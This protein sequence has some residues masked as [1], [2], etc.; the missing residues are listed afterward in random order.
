MKGKIYIVLFLLPFLLHCT[1]KEEVFLTDP[2]AKLSFSEDTVI[3]DTLFADL[4]YPTRRIKVYNRN[5]GAL[6]IS[7]VS[8][9]GGV[10]SPFKILVNGQ[11]GPIVRGLELI[12]GDSLLIVI[13]LFFSSMSQNTPY[14]VED[15]IRFV[16]NGQEQKVLLKAVGRDATLIPAGDLPCSSVWDDTKPIV[17]LGQTVVPAS[18]TLTIQKGTR[19]LASRGSSLD[20]KG[21]L[22]VTGEKAD[23][24]Y[25]GG[26]VSGKNPGQWLGLRFYEGSSGNQL[27]WFHV[28]NAETGMSFVYS[29]APLTNTDI[30]LD[31]AVFND[32]TKCAVDV[33]YTDLKASNCLFLAASAAGTRLSKRGS[34][35]FRY[36]T[37][38]GYSYDYYREGVD[39]EVKDVTGAMSLVLKQSI[40]WGDNFTKE[41]VYDPLATVTADSCIVKSLTTIPGTGTLLNQDPKFVSPV[42]RNYRLQSTSPAIDKGVPSALIT[43]D[44]EGTLR[45]ALPDLGCYEYKP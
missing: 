10:S 44:L 5:G 36:C 38:A 30:T 24:V 18:C 27:S 29:T 16:V 20:I 2:F 1:R 35:E 42:L 31:H 22:L 7:E 11:Q 13:D 39:I 43:D 12:G 25:L 14:L 45:D 17:L 8:L 4:S 3:Y 41:L 15:S 6:S 32:F 26:L 33:S 37:W 34:G 23:S 19:V 28:E 40:V 9:I 21:T